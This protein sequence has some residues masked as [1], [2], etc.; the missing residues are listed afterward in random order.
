MAACIDMKDFYLNNI[1]PNYEYVFF[2]ASL[3]PPEFWEQY[4][5]KIEVD[6]K[7]YVYARVEKGMYG[8]PQVGKVA[9]NALLPRLKALAHSSTRPER[10]TTPC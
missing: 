3:I 4:K 10:W 6:S 5:D 1:L 9:S 2:L 7:G 8:L